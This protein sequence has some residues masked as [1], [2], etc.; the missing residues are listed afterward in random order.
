M[1]KELYTAAL[2]MIPQQ[3]R[4]EMTANNIANAN[5]V[6]YKRVA[7][8]EQSLIEARQNML[9]NK[10]EAEQ[11]DS[12]L[13]QYT[14][15][16][17]GS[18]Q[19]TDNPL[20]LSMDKEGFFVL[21]DDDGN[22]SYTRTGQFQIDENG[23]I[24]SDSGKYLVG[25][26]GAIRIDA[27]RMS[28]GLMSDRKAVSIRISPNGELFANDQFVSRVQAM[29]VENPQT[30]LRTSGMEFTSTDETVVATIPQEDVTIKQGYLE[31]SNVNIITEMI[32]MIQLQRSFE[33]GQKVIT[34]ND[35]TLERSIDMGRFM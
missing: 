16:T 2:G 22:E 35:G 31:T 25:D 24:V 17:P 1:V 20:D 12:P 9:Y 4:L 3:T 28:Q 33:M 13:D 6:G 7:V 14:D 15:F 26:R 10:G 27:A 18:L 11:S 23:M 21:Q 19:R 30:L 32:A 5:S 29:R 8:F 34:T